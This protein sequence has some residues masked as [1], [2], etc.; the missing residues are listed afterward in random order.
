MKQLT[1]RRSALAVLATLLVEPQ[2]HAA[3]PTTVSKTALAVTNYANCPV[4]GTRASLNLKPAIAGQLT[5]LTTLPGP[6]WFNGNTPQTI[7]DGFEYCMAAN[8]AW[9][10]GLNRVIVRNTPF[11]AL[12]AGRANT[13]YDVGLVQVT[14][15]EPRARVVDFTTPYFSSDQGVLARKDANVTA[16]N[17]A[18]KRIGVPSGTTTYTFVNT[19]IRPTS[20]VRVYPDSATMLAALRA[21][22]IDVAL[23]DTVVLLGRVRD[24]GGQA[25]LIGQ[26]RTGEN[27]GGVLPK[28]SP[29]KAAIDRALTELQTN[30]TSNLLSQRFLLPVYGGDPSAV[31]YWTTPAR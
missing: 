22:Q 27:Y 20:Q 19:Q 12:V 14:I 28:G 23:L 25:D 26:F 10:A 17:I 13:R 31:P 1:V 4:T 18:S 15:T 16:A 8:I 6:G 2:A 29:N 9:R 7:R 3:S 24:L 21:N 5:V 30:G 11:D